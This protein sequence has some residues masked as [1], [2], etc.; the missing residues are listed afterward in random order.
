MTIAQLSKLVEAIGIPAATAA[1]LGFLL[2]KL[3]QYILRDIRSDMGDLRSE[4]ASNRAEVDAALR[5]V[6]TILIQQ[7]DRIRVLE[8]NIYRFQAA[9]AVQVGMERVKYDQTRKER[10]DAA[11]QIIRDVG[12]VNGDD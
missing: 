12:K 2:W 6:H 9:I 7:V 11:K 5:S 8:R 1:S 4:M 10:H 3:L